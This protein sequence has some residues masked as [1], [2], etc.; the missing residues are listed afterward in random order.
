[1][2]ARPEPFGGVEHHPGL[3]VGE[4]R[5]ADDE[6]A[7][8]GHAI[9]LVEALA[10]G[11]GADAIEDREQ[12]LVAIRYPR[13]ADVAV[14]GGDDKARLLWGERE[15]I[16]DAYIAIAR[17]AGLPVAEGGDV[18][19]AEPPP[20]DRACTS[21]PCHGELAQPS[22]GDAQHGGGLVRGVGS[23]S[24]PPWMRPL[25]TLGAGSVVMMA[26]LLVEAGSVVS[27]IGPGAGDGASIKPRPD[28]EHA[29]KRVGARRAL[30][31]ALASARFVPVNR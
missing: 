29:G 12:E 26:G 30:G 9:L 3:C 4:G 15:E 17:A 23:H 24:D 18:C 13:R 22:R 25:R 28:M 1:M 5:D 31:K 16:A 20:L 14:Q 8:V 11:I 7:P 6:R 19:V 10:L 2:V 21:A 27:G